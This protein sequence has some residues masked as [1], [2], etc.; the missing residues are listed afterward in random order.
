LAWRIDSDEAR[1]RW[2]GWIV[3]PTM[4]RSVGATLFLGLA[5]GGCAS[6]AEPTG[7]PAAEVPPIAPALGDV[8]Y[9]CG[10]QPGFLPSFVDRPANA[11]LEDHPSA[12]ALRAAIAQAGP[13]IDMLPDSGYWLASRD[14]RIAQYLARDPRG[15]DADFVYASIERDGA[16]WRLGGWGDC[17][18]EIVLEGMSLA[19]WVLDPDAPF[20]A[21]DATTFAALVSERTCTN[22]QPM[23]GRLRPPSIS[24]D[25]TSVVV[26]FAALP[27]IGDAFTCPSNPATR[28]VVE[29]REPLGARDLLDGAF[30]PPAQPIAPQS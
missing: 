4:L 25:P 27:L 1:N 12:V 10:D 23:G 8:R 9:S 30:F 5:L 7:P 21:A 20:P 22:G 14:D 3:S 2:P 18:P 11:E 26:V 19:T 29:L 16:R 17:R 15:D 13:D 6:G 24:Y 28:V